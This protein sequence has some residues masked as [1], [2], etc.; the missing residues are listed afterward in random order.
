MEKLCIDCVGTG[1]C[2]V[3]HVRRHSIFNFQK[4]LQ[5]C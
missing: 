4:S 2:L 1:W 5:V 3:G